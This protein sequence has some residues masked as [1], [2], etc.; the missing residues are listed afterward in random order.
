[1]TLLRVDD[2]GLARGHD[3]ADLN[4]IAALCP[5]VKAITSTEPAAYMKR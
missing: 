4:A 2:D 3:F 5:A 1:L